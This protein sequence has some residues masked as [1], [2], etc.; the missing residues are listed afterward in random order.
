MNKYAIALVLI[1]II[2]GMEGIVA[3]YLGLSVSSVMAKQISLAQQGSTFFEQGAPTE[4]LV[5]LKTIAMGVAVYGVI[6]SFVGIFC[7]AVGATELLE[8]RKK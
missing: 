7:I 2:F 6:K 8:K 4:M 5:F 3:S 1:G